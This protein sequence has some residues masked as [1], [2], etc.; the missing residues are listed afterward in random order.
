[1]EKHGRR[2]HQHPRRHEPVHKN[3]TRNGRKLVHSWT[4]LDWSTEWSPQTAR[5]ACWE[6]LAR[7]SGTHESSDGWWPAA[8]SKAADERYDGLCPRCM[9]EGVV[10][11]ETMPHRA[12]QC[13]ATPRAASSV[14]QIS[15]AR[16]PK[17]SKPYLPVL[18]V[19]VPLP[20]Q[21]VVT[22]HFYFSDVSGN[23]HSQQSRRRQVRWGVTYLKQDTQR[24]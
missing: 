8:K 13:L 3:R 24:A 15:G 12:W 5:L 6:R 10:T 18:G 9:A 22:A 17:H 14:R 16:K 11:V 21:H 7:Q 23:S 20:G 19:L 4:A 1:M 2:F